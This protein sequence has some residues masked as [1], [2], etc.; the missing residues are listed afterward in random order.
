LLARCELYR[1]LWL[2]QNRHLQPA[3]NVPFRIGGPREPARVA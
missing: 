2:V 3:A 1:H